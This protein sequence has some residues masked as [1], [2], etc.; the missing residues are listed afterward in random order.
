MFV[1][2]VLFLIPFILKSCTITKLYLSDAGVVPEF[3]QPLIRIQALHHKVIRFI[4][5]FIFLALRLT[6]TK[7]VTKKTDEI[8]PA[9][10]HL[11]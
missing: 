8:R 5:Q 6:P 3:L 2:R 7:S 9:F 1:V 4:Q 11:K 10:L